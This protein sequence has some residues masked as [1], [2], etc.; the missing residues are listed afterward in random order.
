MPEELTRAEVEN[1]LLKEK[2]K[3]TEIRLQFVLIAFGFFGV[4]L[5][6]IFAAY[7]TNRID[8]T[9]KRIDSTIDSLRKE[10]TTFRSS[11]DERLSKSKDYIA[12]ELDRTPAIIKK[13]ISIESVQM[14][15]RIF[16]S[17]D[18][19]IRNKFQTLTNQFTTARAN[20]NKDL[21]SRY[22]KLEADYKKF[23]QDVSEAQ[24]IWIHSTSN[25]SNEVTPEEY[26]NLEFRFTNISKGKIIENFRV[27]FKD[28]GRES[29]MKKKLVPGQTLKDPK[30]WFELVIIGDGEDNN[31]VA[32]FLVKAMQ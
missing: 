21:V 11:I 12:I 23:E 29:E 30:Y 14:L 10:Y 3:F 19:L 2:V 15:R 26:P 1:I 27:Y 9:I 31:D 4:I 16:A 24:I 6:L 22:V 13:S 28:E 25:K 5:P 32:G 7:S 17:S 18:T 8:N 20:F